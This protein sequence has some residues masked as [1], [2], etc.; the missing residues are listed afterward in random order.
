MTKVGCDYLSCSNTHHGQ[1][2]AY[3]RLLLAHWAEVSSTK[4]KPKQGYRLGYYGTSTEHSFIGKR[5]DGMFFQVSS[6]LAAHVGLKALD[7]CENVSRIDLQCTIKVDGSV[8]EY[9]NGVFLAADN[10]PRRRGRKLRV[11][12]RGG[13]AGLETVYMGSPAS[14]EMGR[15]YDKYEESKD[16]GY[17]GYVRFEVQFRNKR[18]YQIAEVL[19]LSGQPYRVLVDIVAEWFGQ[20]GVALPEVDWATPD[21][22]PKAKHQSSIEG[23]LA[24]FATQVGPALRRA[25]SEAS[26]HEVA[27]ALTQDLKEIVPYN[28]LIWGIVQAFGTYTSERRTHAYATVPTRQRHIP[29]CNAQTRHGHTGSSVDKHMGHLAY[30]HCGS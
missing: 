24:W 14:D 25:L 30:R 5:D 9:I 23:T 22:I 13:S 8:P 17:K 16:E 11:K 27:T 10:A 20:R 18:A 19:R 21:S 26:V 29:S 2:V 12:Y 7:L 3:E 1:Y 28:A 15:V 6:D 4:K